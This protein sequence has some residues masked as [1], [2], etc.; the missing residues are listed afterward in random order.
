MYQGPTFQEI[1]NAHNVAK[2]TLIRVDGDRTKRG[3]SRFVIRD[4]MQHG[5]I[6][7]KFQ[8]NDT[9]SEIRVW[10]NEKYP[11]GVY[12]WTGEFINKTLLRIGRINHILTEESVERAIRKVNGEDV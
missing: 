5:K 11:D 6:I 2:D 4:L 3:E 8:P 1:V 10:I 9:G 7:K 12:I